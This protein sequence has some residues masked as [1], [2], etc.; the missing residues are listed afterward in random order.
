MEQGISPIIIDNTNIKFEYA[1]PY[2]T[3]AN[4]YGYRVEV[5]EPNTPWAFD[6]EGLVKRNSSRAPREIIQ[7]MLST[8]EPHDQF[9]RKIR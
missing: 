9:V 6:V 7:K 5:V 2:I 3:D 8:W 4:K 1:K